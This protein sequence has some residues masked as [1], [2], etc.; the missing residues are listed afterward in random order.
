[1][2]LEKIRLIREADTIPPGETPRQRIYRL[3]EQLSYWKC[4][5]NSPIATEQDI[6]SICKHFAPIYDG[7]NEGYERSCNADANV[8]GQD[9]I[10]HCRKFKAV[11]DWKFRCEKF[12]VNAMGD[13]INDMYRREWERLHPDFV[14]Y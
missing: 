12:L 6:C 2:P 13:I 5:G 4:Y 11:K 9:P 8:T 3:A 7:Y 14:R 1:M 10:W